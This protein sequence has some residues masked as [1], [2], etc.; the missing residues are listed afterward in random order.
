MQY[1]YMILH[2]ASRPHTYS[3]NSGLAKFR[4]RPNFKTYA[5]KL[6]Y[7][8]NLINRVVDDIGSKAST[9]DML[10]HLI[11]LQDMLCPK[12]SIIRRRRDATHLPSYMLTQDSFYNGKKRMPFWMWVKRETIS[13]NTT[14]EQAHRRAGC[15]GQS[16]SSSVSK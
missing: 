4:S 7:P 16:H 8:E 10:D 15:K 6:G 1:A 13:A 3:M 2:I 14:A 12:E 5:S 11:S 9:E